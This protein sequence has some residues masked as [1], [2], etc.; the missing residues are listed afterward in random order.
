MAN[1]AF[2]A[3]APVFVKESTNLDVVSR[4]AHADM[5]EFRADACRCPMS[6]FA[7]PKADGRQ[8]LV[9]DGRPPNCF[10]TTPEDFEHTSG[11]D[12]SRIQ[13]RPGHRLEVAKAD[14]KDFFHSCEVPPEGR[15]DLGV[16]KVRAVALQQ[17]GVQ[18]PA[19]AIDAQGFTHPRLTTLPMGWSPS[20]AIAQGGHEAVLYGCEGNGG[21][22]AQA[23]SAVVRPED[24]LSGRRDPGVGWDNAHALVIDDLML[25]RQ[26][27]VP[28]HLPEQRQTINNEGVSSAPSVGSLAAAPAV[29]LRTVLERYEEAGLRHHPG[30]V[31]DYSP[32]QQLLGYQLADSTLR[33]T[34][35][36]YGSIA[37]HVGDL[38]SR[39]WSRP[40]EVEHLVGRMTN[41]FLLER[42]ALSVFSSVYAFSRRCGHRAARMWPSVLR[43]LQRALAILPVVQADLSRPVAPVLVQTDASG[44][45]LACVYTDTVP[46]RELSQECSRPR[47]LA[48]DPSVPWAVELDLAS[49]F[50]Q[51][52]SADP[53]DWRVALRR[54]FGPGSRE[55]SAHVNENEA[56]A[57]VCAVRWAARSSRTRRCRLVVES[58]SAVAVSAVRKGRSSRPGLLRQC[59]RLAAV[60]LTEQIA[61]SARWVPTSANMADRPSRGD[62]RPGPCTSVPRRQRDHSP[63]PSATDGEAENPGPGPVHAGFWTPLLDATIADST[64]RDY[65]RAVCDFAAFVRDHGDRI[66]TGPDV[67]YWLAYYAHD[68]WSR[69]GGAGRGEV[70]KALYGCEHW[71]FELAPF[72]MARRCVRGWKRL[73]P[74][75]PA[76]PMPLVLGHALAATACLCGDVGA[77]LAMLLSQDAWLRIS[78]VSGLRKGDV[79]DGRRHPDPVH[80]HVA[81]FLSSTKTGPRQAVQLR[82]PQ[83]AALVAA[84]A[85]VAEP[86][87]LLFPSQPDLRSALARALAVLSGPEAEAWETRGLKFTW[88]S[89]RH[90][91]AS[92]AF[93]E[94]MSMGDILA[95]GRWAAEGS[96]RRYIQGGRQLLLA[97]QLPTTVTDLAARVSR[98]GLMTLLSPD[99]P[100]HLRE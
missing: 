79:V 48:A 82:D 30:K 60:A 33:C 49:Q 19:G 44:S 75:V 64:R 26:V 31:Q 16:P 13:V 35:E 88:H 100:V 89:F 42:S 37:R 45:G 6:S 91:G 5:V 72:P 68:R 54:T 74:P 38:A 84:W 14:L 69:H 52:P 90:G 55:A 94:G 50:S 15:D 22:R 47:R 80:R 28:G 40:R 76:A 4:L 85:H 98:C 62:R 2:A 63:P 83:V 10:V 51:R 7:L 41:C 57:I 73:V 21:P 99:L 97:L 71:L 1:L 17:R 34:A 43:E 29:K 56:A 39:G 9:M 11:D 86:G 24:R 66:Q 18:I 70:E 23:L 53:G 36:R 77:G 67:D 96:A 61:V 46:Q 25:F 32:S 20:P 78:E 59:R 92:R 58:D 3:C 8:R 93:L 12:L 65:Y 87:A 81:V 27:P 95:R